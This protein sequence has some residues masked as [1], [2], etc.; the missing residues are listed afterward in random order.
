MA[1]ELLLYALETDASHVQAL[2]N[3]GKTLVI[4]S[5][6]FHLIILILINIS[7]TSFISPLRAGI[8]L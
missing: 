4:F 2:Y 3:L 7:H 1:R 5:I 8:D 6:I